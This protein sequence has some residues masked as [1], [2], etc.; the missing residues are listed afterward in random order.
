M[1]YGCKAII[2]SDMKIIEDSNTRFRRLK[3][4]VIIPTYNNCTTV[5]QV[6][7]GVAEFTCNII[8]VNDG[9]TDA[10]SGILKN[11]DSVE[12]ISY[13]KNKGKGFALKTAFARA[14]ERGFD[15][16]I[17]ID[18]DGQHNPI[19]ISSFL[20]AI[21]K[22]PG[23]LIIGVRN[24]NQVNVPGKNNFANKFSNF[25]FCFITG[26]RLSDTQSGFRLYPLNLIN[27]INLI[28]GKYEFELEILVRAAWKKIKIVPVPVNAYYAPEGKRVSHF[29]PFRD[30]ARISALNT[31]LFFITIFYIISRNFINKVSGKSQ[32]LT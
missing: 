7:K 26:F 2:K 6:I 10:T 24:F 19:E 11:F 17:T 4:C 18:S 15:Y 25:W 27:K 9:S 23:S 32:I 28:T 16:A 30:F 1:I 31:V 21:E 8:V 20:N 29:R 3:C 22:S 13:A 14:L 5:E 12:I